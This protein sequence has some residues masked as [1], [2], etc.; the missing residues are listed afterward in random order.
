MVNLV[1][2]RGI[3]MENFSGMTNEFLKKCC[4]QFLSAE[5]PDIQKEEPMKSIAAAYK[6]ASPIG[7]INNLYY[8]MSNEI[9]NR[10]IKTNS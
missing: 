1:Y 7:W 4:E 3:V 6:E 10:W 8:T 9:V 2:E 5:H